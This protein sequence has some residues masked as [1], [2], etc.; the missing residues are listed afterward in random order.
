MELIPV[1]L[2]VLAAIVII[3]ILYLLI[4]YI[5]FNEFKALTELE[6]ASEGQI[7]FEKSELDD[8]GSNG[9]YTYSVWVYV[10]DWNY[11]FGED[12]NV[13]VRKADGAGGDD[14]FRLYMDK[15]SNNLVIETKCYGSADGAGSVQTCQVDNF[16][17]QTWVCATISQYGRT[18]DVYINGKLVRTCVFPGTAKVPNGPLVLTPSNGG[19]SSGFSGYTCKLR[20]FS[21]ATNPQQAYNIYKDGPCSLGGVGYRLRFEVLQG[22]ESKYSITI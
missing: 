18:C 20:Y 1:L 22:S 19:A 11:G 6:T 15:Q 5:F 3:Y 9:D 2:S 8:G 16:P 7:V 14:A 13:L 4:W 12:K 21:Y 17:L 10:Q